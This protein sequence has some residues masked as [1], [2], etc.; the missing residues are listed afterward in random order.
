M[1]V[2]LYIFYIM[3]PRFCQG[4]KFAKLEAYIFKDYF[5]SLHAIFLGAEFCFQV[6]V[7][8]NKGVVHLL[9]KKR[10]F[11]ADIVENL[12]V[13]AVKKKAVFPGGGGLIWRQLLQ[14]PYLNDQGH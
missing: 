12:G 4:L 8:E 14:L 2:L 3:V 9:L 7:R 1:I 13:S 5:S 10:F 6:K 11:P